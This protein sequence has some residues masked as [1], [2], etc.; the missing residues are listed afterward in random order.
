MLVFQ[1]QCIWQ[2]K[3]F[4]IISLYDNHFWSLHSLNLPLGNEINFQKPELSSM[5]IQS[6][7]W[8]LHLVVPELITSGPLVLPPTGNC[9]FSV[10]HSPFTSLFFCSL[11]CP[12]PITTAPS[13][14]WS[15]GIAVEV[16]VTSL[17]STEKVQNP[18]LPWPWASHW[19]LSFLIY[20]MRVMT[21][22]TS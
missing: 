20:K 1:K 8:R 3:L 11:V 21:R 9:L 17:E 15:P 2:T 22:P 6:L 12:F 19:T 14:Q 4:L 7:W 5:S 16:L 13:L 18:A 10:V